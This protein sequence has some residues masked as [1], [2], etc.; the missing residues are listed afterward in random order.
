M[1]IFSISPKLKASYQIA[2]NRIL[3]A[4]HTE[5]NQICLICTLSPSSA[6]GVSPRMSLEGNTMISIC[7]VALSA[8]L[9]RPPSFVG[10][11]S[12][13][14]DDRTVTK[15][16]VCRNLSDLGGEFGM[17]P[18]TG[19]PHASWREIETRGGCFGRSARKDSSPKNALVSCFDIPSRLL[20]RGTVVHIYSQ[21]PSHRDASVFSQIFA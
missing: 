21:G 14:L 10:S 12:V 15:A 11:F 19:I 1:R 8:L 9:C 16:A 20:K 6:S 5:M 7:C 4:L 18:I 17:E 13:L 3:Q 2:T